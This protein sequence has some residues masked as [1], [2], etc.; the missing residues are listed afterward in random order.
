MSNE[1]NDRSNVTA[2]PTDRS[3]GISRQAQRAKQREDEKAIRSHAVQQEEYKRAMAKP[4]TQE[5]FQKALFNVFSAM[6]KVMAQL[7]KS[8]TRHEA[9]QKLMLQKGVFTN[10][11]Y[12]A[13][14][15]QLA[16]WN[17]KIDTTITS[18]S[19]TPI[20]DVVKSVRDWNNTHELQ[21]E[22]THFDLAP[23]LLAD[24][25]LLLE[26]KLMLAAEMNMPQPYIDHL[27][28]MNTAGDGGDYAKALDG[29][30]GP[31]DAPEPTNEDKG[32]VDIGPATN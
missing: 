12:E 27:R 6:E 25:T 4:V 14:Y 18:F 30:Q 31:Q 13:V 11:E 2:M 5:V 3:G 19:S 10:E 16:E 26:E 29:L 9:T 7:R 20:Q 1:E 22:W 8:G 17:E 15:T 24:T 28:Q 32:I 21:I 23:R